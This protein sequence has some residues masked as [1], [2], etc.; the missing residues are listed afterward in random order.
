MR[1]CC[2]LWIL[3]LRC[4]PFRMTF[5]EGGDKPHTPSFQTYA[6]NGRQEIWNPCFEGRQSARIWH[7][8]STEDRI[9]MHDLAAKR[10]GP[11]P[12]LD[13]DVNSHALISGSPLRS[14]QDDIP[15]DGDKP[16]TCHSRRMRAPKP[17]CAASNPIVRCPSRSARFPWH[18]R[19]I[20]VRQRC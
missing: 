18:K 10:A 20:K 11:L 12:P 17:T 7:E 19:N 9:A 14:V 15:G 5:R 13:Y 3:N 6:D 16:P 2:L 8:P 4:A 1:G